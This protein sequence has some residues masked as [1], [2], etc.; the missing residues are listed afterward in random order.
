[1]QYIKFTEFHGAE[2][3][4]VMKVETLWSPYKKQRIF[5][6]GFPRLLSS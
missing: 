5:I 1:M 6:K 2:I 3:M 4:Y